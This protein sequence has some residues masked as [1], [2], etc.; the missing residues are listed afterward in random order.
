M[1]FQRRM[2]LPLIAAAALVAAPEGVRSDPARRLRLVVGFPA[3]GPLDIAARTIA[4]ALARRLGHEV[5]VE[6]HPGA[7]GN[8]ATAGVVRSAPDGYTLLLCGPVNTINS[9]LFP[10]LAFDFIRDIA[11]VASIARVPLVVEVHPSVPVRTVPELLALAR[12][13][14]GALR[15]AFAGIGTPQHVAIELFQHMA[16][17][18]MTL[19][20]YPG[21]AAALDD[22]LQGKVDLM[23][24]PAPSSM[25][26]LKAGRLIP[27]A[28]TGP[29]RAEMLAEVP[30]MGEFM[31]GYQ[32]GSWF[33][34]GAP[35]GT[36]VDVI[37]RI[38]AAV[39][40]A[41]ADPAVMARF[42]ELGASTMGG[43]AAAFAAFIQAETDKYRAIIRIAS[44][45]PA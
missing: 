3:G 1:N 36:P 12:A 31:P 25:P 10:D 4:P 35:R 37:E 26:H 44:I 9:S 11:P 29:T 17:V 38:N 32:A 40:D 2:F 43:T 20:P 6:N 22:L 8:L 13:S 34:L 41:L 30:A 39:N 23:F 27:L 21:S 5:V 19:V 45:R 33:G 16:G 28:T 7:S 15:I 24:D 14:P 18:R 42:A